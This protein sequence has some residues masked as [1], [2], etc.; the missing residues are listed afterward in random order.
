MI[1]YT[2]TTSKKKTRKPDAKA[3]AL[4]ASWEE[5]LRKYDVQPQNKKANISR[6]SVS[7]IVRNGSSTSHIPSLDNY[8]GTAVKKDIPQYTGDAMIGISVLHK[9]NGVPVFRQ[10]DV[11]DISKM[12]R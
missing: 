12:R 7:R 6:P 3:R 9:S 1:V 11:L 2:K 8:Y 5:I 4:R 10:E